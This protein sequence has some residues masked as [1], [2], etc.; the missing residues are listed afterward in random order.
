MGRSPTISGAEGWCQW[1]EPYVAGGDFPT[2]ARCAAGAASTRWQ[3]GLRPDQRVLSVASSD[4]P[5]GAAV[6]CGLESQGSVDRSR[7]LAHRGDPHVPP[8]RRGRA[9]RGSWWPRR[10]RRALGARPRSGDISSGES[11]RQAKDQ[12]DDIGIDQRA[13]ATPPRARPASGH[14]APMPPQK[15]LG[16]HDEAGPASSGQHTGG[17]GQ[18]HPVG[19][20]QFGAGDLPTD[21]LESFVLHTQGPTYYNNWWAGKVKWTDPGMKADWQQLGQMV[22]NSSGGA[23]RNLTANFANAG[24]PFLATPPQTKPQRHPFEEVP[25]QDVQ[26]RWEHAVAASR[27]ADQG[28]PQGSTRFGGH[29]T[30]RA[31]GP[32]KSLR[33]PEP[34]R[35][36]PCGPVSYAGPADP[37][38]RTHRS[39]VGWTSSRSGGALNDRCRW[40]AGG[41]P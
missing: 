41:S 36:H 21:V 16:P 13:T 11:L 25:G 39:A 2:S 31:R 35:V 17:R 38:R 9:R 10:A 7:S 22:A 37:G 23:N 24:D 1:V 5:G 30:L 26:Q 40:S 27:W 32:W 29:P 12:R 3:E 18:E 15:R 6:L 4:S 8:E 14:Q 19:I 33:C 28:T 20:G 34:A